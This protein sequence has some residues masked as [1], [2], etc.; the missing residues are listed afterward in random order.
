MKI[1]EYI[2]KLSYFFSNILSLNITK[3]TIKNF[4]NYSNYERKDSLIKNLISIVSNEKKLKEDEKKINNTNRILNTQELKNLGF[5]SFSQSNINQL[6]NVYKLIFSKLMKTKSEYIIYPYKFN[7]EKN[8]K[9]FYV[10]Y[11]G[12][13]TLNQLYFSDKFDYI[14]DISS[15]N[16]SLA[17]ALYD[18]NIAVITFQNEEIEVFY[19]S[20]KYCDFYKNL[21]KT[22][23]NGISNFEK[24]INN[25]QTI[26]TMVLVNL[27]D[28]NNPSIVKSNINQFDLLI[29]PDY[30]PEYELIIKNQLTEEVKSQIELF[31][32]NGGHILTSGLSGYLLEILGIIE[33]GTYMTD[34]FL[35]SKNTNNFVNLKG[36]EST[37]NKLPSDSDNNYLLQFLCLG[38]QQKSFVNKIYS[39]NN[40]LQFETLLYIDKETGNLKYQTL[41]KT[42]ID[43]NE[44]D[45]NFPFILV[46]NGFKNGKI[47]IVNGQPL[48][49]FDYSSIITNIIFYSMTRNII[50][51]FYTDYKGLKNENKA[52]PENEEG[53]L[54]KAHYNIYNFFKSTIS[55]VVVNLFLPY[56]VGFRTFPSECIIVTESNN[57][58]INSMN[59]YEY[60]K[61]S[62]DI[63][64]QFENLELTIK[65]EILNKNVTQNS[66]TFSLIYTRLKY[67]D[68]IINKNIV[69]NT[70][71]IIIKSSP[72]TILKGQYY[73]NPTSNYQISGEGIFLDNYLNIEHINGPDIQNVNFITI[74]PLISPLLD[75]FDLGKI[76]NKIE[77][78]DNYYTNHNYKF[79]FNENGTDYDYIDYAE[80]SGKDIINVIDWD[81]PV[82]I[83][84]VM[85]N[86]IDLDENHNIYSPHNR[87][88]VEEMDILGSNI[89]KM[90][91]SDELLKEVFYNDDFDLIDESF[92]LRELVFIDVSKE[93]GA[94]IQ[95]NGDLSKCKTGK[96]EIRNACKYDFVWMRND[97]FFYDNSEYFNPKGIKKKILLTIDKYANENILINSKSPIIKE[98][99]FDS[100]SNDKLIPNEYENVLL[101]N[102]EFEL[103]NLSNNEGKKKLEDTFKGNINFT[104]YI[105][106]VNDKNLKSANSIYNFEMEEGSNIRGYNKVYPDLKFIDGYLIKLRWLPKNPKTG[107]KIIIELPEN[108]QFKD[109]PIDNEYITISAD[110][111]VFFNTTFN[112]N[113]IILY[114]RKG[115]FSNDQSEKPFLCEVYLENIILEPN[116]SNFTVNIQTKSIIR[117]I[118]ELNMES[119]EDEEYKDIID[120]IEYI[121]SSIAIYNFFWSFP[122][123][124]IK[125]QLKD[126]K[127]NQIK[128]YELLIPY[129]RYGIYIQELMTHS[130]IWTQTQSHHIKDPGIQSSSKGFSLLTSIG[131]SYIPYGDYLPYKIKSLIPGTIS[132][133][134]IEWVDN[135][136]INWIHPINSLLF[137]ISPNRNP[138]F[139][140]MMSTTFEIFSCGKSGCNT[141]ERLLVWPSD[142]T[143]IIR[144][145]VKFVNKFSKYFT[146]VICQK[147]QISYEFS[148][149]EFG[150]DK[151]YS[152]GHNNVYGQCY[153]NEN[154]CLS[155]NN[156]N[157]EN[158]GYTKICDINDLEMIDECI[159]DLKNRNPSLLSHKPNEDTTI[160]CGTETYNY[161]PDVDN[162]YPKG[163]INDNKMW[164][165]TKTNYEDNDYLK[166]FPWHMDNNL[167]GIDISP[168]QNPESLKPHNF[169]SFPIFK[170]LGYEI[171]YS[172]TLEL[173][174]K[175]SGYK[176]WWSDNLQNKDSTLLAGQEKVNEIP[177]GDSLLKDYNWINGKKL[178]SDIQNRLKNI[179]VC[180]FNQHRVKVKENQLI[181]SYPNNVYQNNVIPVIYD[182]ETNDERLNQYVCA[183]NQY[184]PKKISEFE[185]RLYTSTDKD[186]LYFS[187]NLRGEAKEN[188]NILMKII[189]YNDERLFE[190]ETLIYNGGK[191]TYWNPSESP[192]SFITIENEPIIIDSY[193]VDLKLT[194]TPIPSKFKTFNS[195]CFLIEEIEDPAENL[196]EY[197]LYNY[198]NSYGFGDSSI[199]VFTGGIKGTSSRVEPGEI[200][201]VKIT[202]FNNA[203]FDWKL[204]KNAI[205]FETEK[206][207]EEYE[208]MSD[209]ISVVPNPLKYNFIQ[210]IIPDKI[211]DYIEITPSDHFKDESKIFLLYNMINVVNINDGFQASYY[212]KIKINENFPFDYQGRIWNISAK[213]DES[214]FDKLPGLNDPFGE[215]F[216]DYKLQIPDIKFGI[217][218]MD[219]EYKGK[220]FNV[221]QKSSNFIFQIKLLINYRIEEIL[222]ID[223]EYVTEFKNGDKI[224]DQVDKEKNALAIW[225]K[226]ELIKDS[227]R[228]IYDF[229]LIECDTQF[230]LLNISLYRYIPYFPIE[231]L[232]KPDKNKINVLIKLFATN[233][234]AGTTTRF[235]LPT[236][237]Y[238]DGRKY[239]TINNNIKHNIWARG[240]KLKITENHILIINNSISYGEIKYN[241]LYKEDT[242]IVNINITIENSGGA[243]AE[244]VNLTLFIPKDII[245][246]EEL[247]SQFNII[248]EIFEEDDKN[249]LIIRSNLNIGTSKKIIQPLYLRFNKLLIET[250]KKTFINNAEI[251]FFQS[252]I[253]IDSN[254]ITFNFSFDVN[255]DISEGERTKVK[256]EI[257][258]L[259]NF[260]EPKYKVNAITKIS[261]QHINK[262]LLYYFSRK[263][264]D[265]NWEKITD[266]INLNFIEDEPLI[267]FPN[268]MTEYIIYYKVEIFLNTNGPIIAGDILSFKANKNYVD[269]NDEVENI[270]NKGNEEK[271]ENGEK[272]IDKEN[273]N[274]KNNEKQEENVKKPFFTKNMIILF[275][276][277]GLI[278]LIIIILFF[279]RLFKNEDE[280][281]EEMIL[282][283][284]EEKMTINKYNNKNKI[285]KKKGNKRNK[286]E[287]KKNIN[288]ISNT[289]KPIFN[290]EG[291]RIS[292][293]V[294][295]QNFVKS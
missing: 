282:K 83:S 285:I 59:T 235:M 209:Y 206:N 264:G 286:K 283:D 18:I 249:I 29:I 242:G 90:T 166:G 250:V 216:H 197:K 289:S 260:N 36:C 93:K 245:I 113:Q 266:K 244:E 82:K 287:L 72:L 229:E 124:Y 109:D 185:N 288:L 119:Y 128:K 154:S 115:F 30:L 132:T 3:E 77:I 43:L 138:N 122:A 175:F 191:F 215:T 179:Y 224:Q 22:C 270:E 8:L 110:N 31:I 104:H 160:N 205:E 137:N 78:Y 251:I 231:N 239:K 263:I 238:F 87:I 194:S 73:I 204:K 139:N 44:D 221:I 97:L 49:N 15:V 222:L 40:I 6:N 121:N 21:S 117:D 163:Y 164:D 150:S 199:S 274:T 174:N 45:N 64:N 147:N 17:Q 280:I 225:D 156:V 177:I 16:I 126:N 190:G 259:R 269:E 2:I 99:S 210:L 246:D 125:N 172:K 92:N 192:N 14:R 71:E 35:I 32:K 151:Q 295:N 144:F 262:N 96:D 159:N 202:F 291:T 23:L 252:E 62:K 80:L 74:I 257:N 240:P 58:P 91:N 42:E 133:S 247:L 27:I 105:I 5:I 293:F 53:L 241:D 146:P 13:F 181:Y 258:S 157:I 277:V 98:G 129:S 153:N 248:N 131:I 162:Y 103:Y 57:E 208:F 169:L 61:C 1:L 145:Y 212:Y 26:G 141:Q 173:K 237:N 187:L 236:L 211:K 143:A 134:R 55:N 180:L 218:Y 66:R 25:Y 88:P 60:L 273:K 48:N 68:D 284:D 11:G 165:L 52:I 51:D 193:R 118:S 136:L 102:V 253:H 116:Y 100:N 142:E 120:N 195:D 69:Y 182:L 168:S 275:I 47:W 223:D 108:V 261:N 234:E 167:P 214:Y 268:D 271:E 178:N 89:I 290:H 198:Q 186:W 267:D 217:P 189:P 232:G 28:L 127:K 65:I 75:N 107:G 276:I 155:G 37:H 111:I 94:E 213:I 63:I 203:G 67:H 20:K 256:L 54:I 38:A 10:D 158:I 70:G 152:L 84:K 292:K 255:S 112:D 7:Y 79:P 227:F 135:W 95:Y 196:R 278:I 130:T 243:S 140:L 201:Y 9:T 176:G 123:L 294:K 148:N 226:I 12:V 19:E 56:G 24:N 183:D 85:R 281:G 86:D 39:M 254:N 34:K 114:Y 170:G 228:K 272:E 81:T 233:L 220:I 207:I 76:I 188:L 171:E 101:N 161:S 200:T 265:N 4:K 106:P 184:T 33:S 50:Y 230:N 41:D 149:T 46:K 279:L 219:G